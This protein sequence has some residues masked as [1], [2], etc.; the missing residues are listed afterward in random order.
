MS[1]TKVEKLSK[2]EV[3]S[4][5]IGNDFVI[6]LGHTK[7]T[8]DIGRLSV[9]KGIIRQRV[10]RSTSPEQNQNKLKHS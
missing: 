7:L 6:A 9:S 1:P 8:A 2:K 5:G 3:T 10:A 4:F